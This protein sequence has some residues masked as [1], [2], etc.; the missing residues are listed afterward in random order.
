MPFKTIYLQ[1]QVLRQVQDTELYKNVAAFVSSTSSCCRSKSNLGHEDKLPDIAARVCCQG[2][3]ILAGKYSSS[4]QY[5]CKE[6]CVKCFKYNGDKPVTLVSATVV[7]GSS[8]Q[9]V[10]MLLSSSQMKMNCCGCGP[11]NFI[12]MYPAGSDVLTALLLAL[13]PETWSGIKDEKLVQGM[14][15]L[16][17]IEHLPTLLQEEVMAVS[18]FIVNLVDSVPSGVCLKTFKE[19]G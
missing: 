13:P 9:G 18:S 19:V 11:N 14:Y 12:G 1:E 17:S 4:S 7:D 5:C 16:V 2:A 10:D 8:E 15:A 6:T 3:E